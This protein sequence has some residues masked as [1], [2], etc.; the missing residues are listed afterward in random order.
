MTARL[1]ALTTA[2]A[3]VIADVSIW[4]VHRVIDER[5]LPER[6]YTPVPWRSFTFQRGDYVVR[7]NSF[8]KP[9]VSGA[10]STVRCA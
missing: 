2:E 5:I 1:D 4:D 7:R 3:A 9:K 10:T 6:F 8:D